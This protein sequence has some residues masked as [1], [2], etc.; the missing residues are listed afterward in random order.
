M[1][2][3]NVVQLLIL[4]VV[5]VSEAQNN[6]DN[7]PQSPN[8]III[9]ADDLGYAD[10]SFNGSKDIPTPN[11]DK[12]AH[13]GAKFTNAYVT[14]AVCGPSR[15]GLITGR[16]QDRFGYGRNPLFAPNDP[17]MG[18]PKSEETIAEVLKKANYK[19]VALGKWHLG[20]H[21]TLRP[22]NRGFDDFFGFLSG[23]HAYFPELWTLNDEYQVKKQYDA[24]NT[25]LLRNTLR[26][27][28]KEY[29]TDALSREAVNYI[30]KYKDTPFFMYLAYNAPHTPLQAS[31]E[32]LKRFPNI[33]DKKRKTYA[34]M[35][36]AMDDGVG[37]VLAKLE[38]LGLT[39]NT[40]VFF[41]SDNGGPEHHNG[42]D[43]GMLR[44]GKSDLFE[45]GIRVPFAMRW[46]LKLPKD[47]VYDAPVSS[48]DIFATLIEQTAVRVEPKNKLDG[49]DLMP[50]LLGLEKNLPH[51][52]LFWRKFDSR[53]FAVRDVSGQK[54]VA[55]KDKTKLFDLNF[56]LSEK[57]SLIK[58]DASLLKRLL[59]QYEQWNS[60]MTDPIFLG[61]M[62]DDEYNKSHPNR[63]LK[64][65]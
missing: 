10:V 53:Q 5:L 29:L 8:V 57:E 46:P 6:Q 39:E 11:I 48:L 31:D 19:S 12:I 30:E 32:Y 64:P 28:E 43:N 58:P 13:E 21:E 26:I 1:K 25:K 2:K 65:Q 47:I 54:I 42:S 63:F 50:H 17:N 56:N 24:Y 52:F 36:S 33:T 60:E 3:I 45:G 40:I 22:L 23:G 4:L 55:I 41:L 16:Y 62:S 37:K 18:L 35:V 38:D 51:E 9:L 44:G 7:S 49:K 15:A 59:Q 20:A 27:E 34:A 14:Y 61:L